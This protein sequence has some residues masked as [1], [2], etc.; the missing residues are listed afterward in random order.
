MQSLSNV[1]FLQC[2]NNVRV[3]FLTC[4]CNAPGPFCVGHMDGVV[5]GTNFPH[6][7]AKTRKLWGRL[8]DAYEDADKLETLILEILHDQP[9][10][11]A[12]AVDSESGHSIRQATVARAVWEAR[13][14]L[15]LLVGVLSKYVP[16]EAWN[17]EVKPMCDQLHG[18][19][20]KPGLFCGHAQGSKELKAA[21][22]ARN[23]PENASQRKGRDGRTPKNEGEGLIGMYGKR[24]LQSCRCDSS[25]CLK[26]YCTCF[27]NETRCNQACV[28]TECHNDGMHE[29]ERMAAWR[30]GCVILKKPRVDETKLQVQ[31]ACLTAA[32]DTKKAEKERKW[33]GRAY[34]KSQIKVACTLVMKYEKRANEIE[35]SRGENSQHMGGSINDDETDGY[36]SRDIPRTGTFENEATWA[37]FCVATAEVNHRAINLWDRVQR[38]M[39]KSLNPQTPQQDAASKNEQ[40]FKHQQTAVSTSP[41]AQYHFSV[42]TPPTNRVCVGCR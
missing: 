27:R 35:R 29:D 21:E 15:N 37:T 8:E 31:A 20:G 4:S 36:K 34:T 28:C 13:P 22:L 41:P 18:V 14:M 7:A 3:M 9:T 39:K 30:I 38:D 10:I 5:P 12:A 24:T 16:V 25:K 23:P 6:S 1:M 17:R 42:N 11:L 2:V 32:S 19:F 33:R 40:G 26:M